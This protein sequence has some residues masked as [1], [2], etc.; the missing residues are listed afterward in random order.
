MTAFAL[1]TQSITGIVNI[2]A[3]ATN[4]KQTNRTGEKMVIL[5]NFEPTS[6]HAKRIPI[7]VRIQALESVIRCYKPFCEQCKTKMCERG[8]CNIAQEIINAH[9]AMF[10]DSIEQ[11]E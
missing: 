11:G 9:E 1:T 4:P 7:M 10:K 8:W 2:G 5:N 6:E 3:G